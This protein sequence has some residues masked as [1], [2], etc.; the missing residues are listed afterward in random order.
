MKLIILED[1]PLPSTCI[2]IERYAVTEAS[3]FTVMTGN[4]VLGYTVAWK[5]GIRFLVDTVIF[6]QS[7]LSDG[8]FTLGLRWLQ[9]ES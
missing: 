6:P 3:Y 7:L 5:T 2:L 4:Y 9:R 1:L 8:F